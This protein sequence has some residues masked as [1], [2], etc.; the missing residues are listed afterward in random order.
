VLVVLT[1]LSSILTLLAFRRFDQ[2]VAYLKARR[3]GTPLPSID[4]RVGRLVDRL[5]PDVVM[6]NTF[7]RM[8]HIVEYMELTGERRKLIVAD[9][10]LGTPSAR[11][12]R[13]HQALALPRPPRASP[14]DSELEPARLG[15]GGFV[16]ETAV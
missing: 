10:H 13:H 8:S 6:I 2:K 9:L 5:V 1:V 11:H 16:Q 14:A 7:P 3:D 4:G 15:S 12:L